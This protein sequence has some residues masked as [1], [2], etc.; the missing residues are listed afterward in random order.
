MQARV[1]GAAEGARWVL[2]GWRIFRAAPVGWVAIVMAYLL[3]VLIASAIPGIG[4][5]AIALATPAFSVSFMAI[6]RSA[7]TA[8]SAQLPQLFEGF[9]QGLRSQL[10]LGAVY[11]ACIVT[12]I[13]ITALVSGTRPGAEADASEAAPGAGA[14]AVFALFF[15]LYLPTVMAFW[16]A[17][18]LAAW[19]SV[20]PAKALFF[21]FFACLMNWRAFLAYGAVLAGV[22]FA[23]SAAAVLAARLL[24]P[25]IDATRLALPMLIVVY[26]TV[27]ASYYAS[28][29]DVFGET[30]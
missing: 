22:I 10:T 18:V 7:S 19:H 11:F 14:A 16:F 30:P 8:G 27:L 15:L 25:G 9:R 29:R 4:I 26:P 6:A 23:L 3:V 17:P 12:A 20:G 13:G 28:Y 5:A 1:V 24:M 21:S 2:R